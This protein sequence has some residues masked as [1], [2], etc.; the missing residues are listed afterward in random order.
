M[1]ETTLKASSEIASAVAGR[2]FLSRRKC[3]VTTQMH[4]AKITPTKWFASTNVRADQRSPGTNDGR[5]GPGVVFLKKVV[6]RH[7]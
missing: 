5:G 7:S 6:V 4:L 1:Y 2:L 3:F